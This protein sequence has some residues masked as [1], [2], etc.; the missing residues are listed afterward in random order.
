MTRI[1]RRT[2]YALGLAAVTAS[3]A[4]AASPALAIDPPAVGGSGSA[5]SFS[6]TFTFSATADEGTTVSGYVGGVNGAEGPIASGVE[7]PGIGIGDHVFRVKAVQENGIES[8]YAELPFAVLA[9]T[10]PPSLGAVLA[11]TPTAAGWFNALTIQRSPCADGESGLPAGACD[12]TPWT[13]NGSFAA[14]AQTVSATDLQGNTATAPVPAF[15]FDN[16]QPVLGAGVPLTPSSGAIVPE[17]PTFQ[18]SPGQ[19]LTS[20]VGEY[21][22]QIRIADPENDTPPITT[23]ARVT[24][25]GGVGNYTTARQPALS[26]DPMPEG[27][28]IEWRVRTIDKAGNVR[29]SDWWSIRIDSTIPPA[30]SITAGPTGP[31]RDTSPAFSWQG[32]Q[33]TYKWD[34]R[35]AGAET[36][37]REGAGPET[38]TTLSSLPD[39]DYIFRVTQVT[40]AGRGSAEATR[41]FQVNTTPPAPPTILARPTFP[42]ITA[43]V[44]TWSAEPGAYSRWV[45]IGPSGAAIV[46]PVNTPVTNAELPPLANG[47]YS[48]QVQQIDPAGNVSNATSE[49]FTV[50]APL[51]PAPS[52]SGSAG[53]I[54][55]LALPKQNATRLKPK[56]GQVVPT[57]AP[58]LKWT[59]GP[60]GT[61]L[62]NLQIFRV[63]Q[64]TKAGA[65]PKV[66]KIYSSFPKGLQTRA[67]KARLKAGT[68]YVW[69][70]WPYTGRAFTPKPVG[71]SNFCT[72]SAK[73]IKLKEKQARAKA[74]KLR[75]ARAKR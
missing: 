51:V 17:E 14:G 73:V 75:A 63:T 72:A 16:V 46:G 29:T 4:V 32:T 38:Q 53:T 48:F 7:I 36:P 39:G 13:Q 35:R 54:A 42:A 9:D 56:A 31:S 26:P 74:A 1:T 20:G 70:V 50:L 8:G 5:Y 47:A 22:V 24:D 67:P 27:K 44:F 2:R 61:R 52:P 15:N 23:I 59:K 64:V 43:P 12:A 49:P 3:V 68:C 21:E 18:W 57:L 66:T 28:K 71:V 69:R 41:T 60:R 58:V 40:E 33:Q 65:T 37:V 25:T 11:G 19:D 30:P 62:Y 6:R 55:A 34:V 10:T 45:V